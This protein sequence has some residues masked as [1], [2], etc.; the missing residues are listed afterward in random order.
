MW[1]WM[2]VLSLVGL[3]ALSAWLDGVDPCERTSTST[4]GR[5]ALP[6]RWLAQKEA[7]HQAGRVSGDPGLERGRGRRGAVSG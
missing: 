5:S 1:F 7:E 3:A 2:I 6:A 4:G